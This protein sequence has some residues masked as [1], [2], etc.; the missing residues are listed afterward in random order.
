MK[1]FR[2]LGMAALAAL[3]AFTSAQA[4]PYVGIQLGPNFPATDGVS[5]DGHFFRSPS[6][7]TGLAVGG[8]VGFD[9][10][11]SRYQFP[12]WAKYF[13]VAGDYTF[14]TFDPSHRMF[15]SYTGNQNALSFLAIAKYPLMDSNDYPLGRLF[16]YVGVGP[17]IVWTSIGNRTA[18]NVGLVVEPGV[19]YMITPQIS[20]DVAY[21]F[22]YTAPQF[23]RVSFDNYSNMLLFRVNYHF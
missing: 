20:G 23:D 12:A 14:N 18:T 13:G 2:V 5:S 9:F 22:R 21:R 3:L 16:P 4:G 15:H 19:R 7:D 17:G 1:L 11:D 8:Q 6:F 10:N